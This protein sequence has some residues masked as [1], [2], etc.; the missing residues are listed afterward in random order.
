MPIDVRKSKIYVL[1]SRPIKVYVVGE[2]LEY[3]S[4][5]KDFL[6]CFILISLTVIEVYEVTYQDVSENMQSLDLTSC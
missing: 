5:F 1:W 3:F 6:S 4:L 2:A